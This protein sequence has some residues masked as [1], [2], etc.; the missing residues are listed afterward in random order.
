[1]NISLRKFTNFDY[2]LFLSSVLLSIIGIIFIYSSGVN[3]DGILVNLDYVKQIVWFITGIILL[4]LMTLFYDYRR[5]KDRCLLI[6]ICGITLLV[7]TRLFGV[8]YRNSRSWI[9]IENVVGIQPSEFVKLIFILFLAYY[10][11]KSKHED[12]LKRFIKAL[13]IMIV[14]V[15]LILLQPD[16]GTASVYIPIFLIMCFAAGIPARFV[17]FV[18][19]SGLL[20][21]IFTL[22]PLWETLILKKISIMS[23]L[24]NTQSLSLII[25]FSL[26]IST[27][28]A[29]LGFLLIKKRYYYW[30]AYTL[31]IF[32]IAF[33]G[34]VAGIHKLQEYQMKRLIVFLAPEADPFDAGWNIIQ[35][36][37]A[38]GAGGAFGMG[39]LNG[40]QSH[41]GY[42]PEKSTDFIFSIL[43]EEWGFFTG[44]LVVFTL[45][46]LLF[47]RLLS[48]IKRCEDLFG[49]LIATGILA[50]FFFHFIVNIGMVM[51]I[52]PITGIPLMFMSYGGSSLWVSMIAVG[53]ILGIN[54]RQVA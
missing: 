53:I 12:P 28:L 23:K 45:Y 41:Y 42:L 54:L 52:M 38:I 14:P 31:A 29:W 17:L 37:T 47:L 32:T 43:S 5:L 30:I 39:F 48:C 19:I 11:D 25:F 22:I 33:S 24:V 34:A 4:V 46:T 13:L 15:G 18:F 20:S 7:Y 21:V 8:T 16:L 49:K 1:M 26:S 36:I 51:G 44:G 2:L 9:G 50:M 3:S 35:S 6:Y 40:T 27:V 10:L